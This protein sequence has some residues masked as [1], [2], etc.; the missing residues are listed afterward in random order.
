MSNDDQLS[1]LDDNLTEEERAALDDDTGADLE[2]LTLDE[3]AAQLDADQD[4]DSDNETHDEDDDAPNTSDKSNNENDSKAETDD[5]PENA[6]A[7]DLD[8]GEDTKEDKPSS[9]EGEDATDD[10]PTTDD[11]VSDDES[12]ELAP[13]PERLNASSANAKLEELNEKIEDLS[14]ER[15]KIAQDLDDGEISALE[16]RKKLDAI[17]AQ[18]DA[19]KDAVRDIRTDFRLATNDARENWF[20]NVVPSFN[21][22]N[23][24]YTENSAMEQLLDSTVRTL[25][26]QAAK[27]GKNPLSPKILTI[28]HNRIKKQ[29]PQMFGSVSTTATKTADKVEKPKGERARVPTL[30]DVPAAA[31]DSGLTNS[32]FAAIDRLSGEEYEKA[33]MALSEAEQ[34]EYLA[35]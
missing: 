27:E 2:D 35:Q 10:A 19:S 21:E 4:D 1:I 7:K 13:L 34:D 23:K 30:A 25:Q 14:A 28:A 33:F 24:I 20:E 11:D 16:H 5:K 32:K 31:D 29:M 26:Q 12:E 15:L 18:M 3:L 8:A 6:D 9:A 22:Q 17:E